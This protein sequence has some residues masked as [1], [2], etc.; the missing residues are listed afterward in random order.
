MAN[1]RLPDLVPYL[2]RHADPV[3]WPVE[4]L[5]LR[6]VL[7]GPD[8]TLEAALGCLV[9]LPLIDLGGSDFGGKGSLLEARAAF[10]SALS[11]IPE[12]RR[13][14]SEQQ[15]QSVMQILPH[16]AVACFHVASADF[17]Y[18]CKQLYHQWIIFDDLWA[19][20]NPAMAHSLFRFGSRWD[21]LGEDKK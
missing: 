1:M 9:G 2:A 17:S 10:D 13:H 3:G 20:A 11:R 15:T 16:L 4:L 5:M 19:T 8:D 7:K 14:Q 21:V 18:G 6:A 12:T